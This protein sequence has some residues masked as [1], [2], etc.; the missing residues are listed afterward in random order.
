MFTG[1]FSL[2]VYD[3]LA[4]VPVADV[5]KVHWFCMNPRGNSVEVAIATLM[6]DVNASVMS[7]V[8]VA[9]FA[10]WE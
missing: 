6:F 9:R 10:T 3:M 1:S 8:L 7:T 5:P 2:N 4:A